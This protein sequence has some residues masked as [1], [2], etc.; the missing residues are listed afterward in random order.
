MRLG[1][2]IPV[3]WGMSEPDAANSA[4]AGGA[5]INPAQ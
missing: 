5:E 4:Y 2:S 3:G 1:K